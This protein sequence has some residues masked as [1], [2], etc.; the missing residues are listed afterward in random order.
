MAHRIVYNGD[1]NHSYVWREV[2]F[3]AVLLSTFTIIESCVRTLWTFRK[4]ERQG[5]NIGWEIT[6][7]PNK[8]LPTYLHNGSELPRDFVPESFSLHPY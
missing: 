5:L 8:I 1:K 3:V 4:A 2:C 6:R 7:L